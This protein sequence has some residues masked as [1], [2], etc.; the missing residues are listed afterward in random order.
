MPLPSG[1]YAAAVTPRRPG[2]G[3]INL[4]VLWD[5]FDFLCER[6][7]DGIVLLASTGEFI[8]YSDAERTRLVE[9]AVRRSRVPVIVN[10]SHSTLDGAVELAQAA[11]ASGAGAVL[12]MPPYFFQYDEDAIRTFILRFA[13]QSDIDVPL[14]LYNLPQFGNPI[15]SR[16]AAELISQGVM[17][18]IEDSSGDRDYFS[19]LIACRQTK[20]FILMAGSDI[21]YAAVRPH[22]IH[23]VISDAACAVPELLVALERA[24]RRE[25][26]E[27]FAQLETRLAEFITRIDRFAAPVGIRE[28]LCLRQIKVGPN[29]VPFSPEGER[30][31]TEF[32]AW[33][34]G[35]L[36]VVLS[37]CRNA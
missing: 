10:V 12:L 25:A 27:L 26:R 2:T 33:F 28:A 30:R 31:I 3:D 24:W 32:R 34:P 35:W 37:E 29:A 4:G 36:K 21:L 15:S 5:L 13:E 8:H 23:G 19:T 20:E 16:L 7:V 22:K 14:L 9:L 11:A 18:G 17:H 1:V 6:K